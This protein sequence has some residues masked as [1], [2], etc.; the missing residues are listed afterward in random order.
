LLLSP[1][2]TN[3]VVLA[4]VAEAGADQTVEV[5]QIAT[6]DGSASSDPEGAV[7]TYSWSLVSIPSGSNAEI[8]NST[9]PEA[10]FTPDVPGTYVAQLI[11][12]N[13]SVPSEPDTTTIQAE[14]GKTPLETAIEAIEQLQTDIASMPR[15]AFRYVL[16]KRLLTLELNLVIASLE[17]GRNRVALILLKNNILPTTDGCF[18]NG[19]PDRQDWIVDCGA[20]GIVYPELQEII[21]MVKGML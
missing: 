2:A 3:A 17:M 20:Q 10:T 15:S 16:S 19:V 9:E 7:L 21:T 18:K 14:S 4:P 11:V 6:L 13:G 1:I 8:T 12:N 5:G